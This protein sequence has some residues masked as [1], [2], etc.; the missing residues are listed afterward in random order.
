MHGTA[1]TMKLPEHYVKLNINYS[2]QKEICSKD[3]TSIPHRVFMIN[4][5]KLMDDLREIEEE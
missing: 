2:T 3:I 4:D 5:E 1:D